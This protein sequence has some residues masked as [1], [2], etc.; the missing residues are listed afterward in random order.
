M[1]Q[2]LRR[3][4]SR[5]SVCIAFLLVLTSYAAAEKPWLEVR[6][7]HFRVL[8]NGTQNQGREVAH[9]FEQM[10]YVFATRF[11]KFR[12][13]SGAPLLILAARDEQTQKT[14]EPM[15]AKTKGAKWVGEYHHGWDKQF[16]T[17]RLD[18]WGTGAREI[19][20]HEYTHS[21]MHMNVRWLPVWLDEGIAEFYAYTRFQQ[22]EIYLGA[23]SERYPT[24]SSAVLFP[25]EG[26]IT[27]DQRS[28]YYHDEMK[29]QV[30]YA[31]SW[32]LVHY[33]VFG[34]DME[35]G[36]KLD[37]F[38]SMIQQGADQKK[39]FQ[40]VFGNFKEVDK[41]LQLYIRAFQL[42]SGVVRDPPQLEDKDFLYHTLTAAETE[43]EL[44][45]F[46]LW[47]R[48]KEG[49]HGL[50]Q[51]AAKDGAKLGLA[52]EAMGFVN[53]SEGKDAEALQ[54]FSQATELD[55]DLYLS[56]FAKTMMSAMATS[57]DAT[58]ES[59]LENILG[60]VLK[61]NPQFAPAYVQLAKL[62]LRRGD[63]RTA[64]AV[65][66]KAEQLEP[67]RAGYHI[68]SGQ[69]LHRLGREAEA[70]AFASFVAERWTG[71]DH[72]EAVEL[73]N[74]IPPGTATRRDLFL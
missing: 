57:Y 56:S 44:A 19:V 11:P 14:L 59:S 36:R 72:N 4:D 5:P 70:A 47:T 32:A 63:L 49:A 37:R 30:F 8:T 68:L 38:F 74:S 48:D 60:Q 13:E 73:W 21:I 24:L 17:I 65:S 50:A 46:H 39:A 67:A 27:A 64:L 28:P 55:R 51:Q 31:E 54:E 18:G 23:P 45:E 34:P 61:S 58:D 15:L 10:R 3:V 41:A 40:E 69:I 42:K 2:D 35:G 9:E 26:L 43:A 52:H 33:M 20:Y 1:R 71:P 62:A 7:P 16:V 66:R 12:L 25:V 6:S 53:F 22:H 29:A